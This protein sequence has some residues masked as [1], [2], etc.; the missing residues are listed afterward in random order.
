MRFNGGTFFG[1]H[2]HV[3]FN[4]ASYRLSLAEMMPA[5]GIKADAA[6][7]CGDGDFIA[8]GQHQLFA[9]IETP[10]LLWVRFLGRI[11]EQGERMGQILESFR[12]VILHYKPDFVSSPVFERCSHRGHAR[13]VP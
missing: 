12:R 2:A 9:Q 6:L 7:G 4:P 8:D 11:R 10:A 3:T 13:F 5:L 1:L